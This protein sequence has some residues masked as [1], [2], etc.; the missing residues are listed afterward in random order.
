MSHRAAVHLGAHR[1]ASVPIH[2]HNAKQQLTKL[3]ESI[4]K[5]FDAYS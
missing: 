3:A 4:K 2:Q 5:P 1:V